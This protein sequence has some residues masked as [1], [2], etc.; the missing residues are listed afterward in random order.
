MLLFDGYVEVIKSNGELDVKYYKVK[1][2]SEKEAKTKILK[3]VKALKS[4]TRN[5]KPVLQDVKFV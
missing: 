3:K 1:A 4:I 5:S 2:L